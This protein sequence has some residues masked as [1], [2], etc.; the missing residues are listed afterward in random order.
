MTVSPFLSRIGVNMNTR[1]RYL[2]LNRAQHL[3][4]NIVSLL[5]SLI[6]LDLKV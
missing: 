3:H 1:A 5:Q 4:G 6:A 2:R